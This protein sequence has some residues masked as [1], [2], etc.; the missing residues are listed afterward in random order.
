MIDRQLYRAVTLFL[1]VKLASLS[2]NMVRFPVL[3]HR[4]PVVGRTAD[5]VS[6]LVP[7]RNEATMLAR[8]VPR[9]LR[10]HVHE[11]IIL[12]DQSTDG[13][14]ECARSWMQNHPHARVVAGAPAPPGWVG[15]SW[16]CH[17][18]SE[19]A[20]GSLLV[21]CDADVL[22]GAGAVEAAVAEM[23]AQHADVFSVFPRQITGTWGE[24]LIIPLIDDV[25][26]CFLP[27]GLLSLDVP[28]AATANGS[29]FAFT[30]SAYTH[31]Q[32]F[33]AVR[34]HLGIEDVM[35]ARRT[36]RAGLKLGLALGGRLVE[37][38]MYTGYAEVIAGMGRGL[39]PVTGGSRSRLMAAA[40]W[41]VLAYFLPLLLAP[42]HRRWAIPL[43][44]GIVER[45]LVDVKTQRHVGWSIL[46][47]PLSP[48]AALPL[49]AQALRAR[50][51]WK[52]RSYS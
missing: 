32:G 11:L 4:P 47:A 52:G 40:A 31:L 15:K 37:T 36:R 39:L 22:L 48:V 16:A 49:F 45:A 29:L 9:I 19:L 26:L 18:L 51:Q 8:S 43:T 3:R 41:H 2:V 27:F 24:R 38:R 30:R 17:Q 42:T 6:L 21:F 46:L 34:E 25:L 14:A 35:M 10:Q 50:Q 13:S 28:A 1:I 12:D 7:M 33:A 23:R 5:T 44:L 20:V